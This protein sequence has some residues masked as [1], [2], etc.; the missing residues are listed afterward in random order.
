M[1]LEWLHTPPKGVKCDEG[2]HR[3]RNVKEMENREKDISFLDSFYIK[4]LN[5]K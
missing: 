3:E 5:I 2:R 4:G 1:R